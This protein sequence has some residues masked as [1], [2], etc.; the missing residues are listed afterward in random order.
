MSIP[1]LLEQIV[2]MESTLWGRKYR[3]LTSKAHR[4][5][6][7]NY[8]RNERVRKKTPDA[9]PCCHWGLEHDVDGVVTSSRLMINRGGQFKAMCGG[10]HRL[11]NA[12]AR[13]IQEDGKG[14]DARWPDN[15]KN[16]Y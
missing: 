16:H 8:S 10:T 7:K 12:L 15:Q 13:N 2:A 5:S 9:C 4:L 6:L 3:E 14:S 1:P 11:S